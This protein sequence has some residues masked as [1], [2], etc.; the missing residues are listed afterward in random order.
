MSALASSPSLPY[1]IN[2]QG[3]CEGRTHPGKREPENSRGKLGL[4]ATALCLY[5]LVPIPRKPGE[6]R[7]NKK[8]P[9]TKEAF[10]VRASWDMAA[11][12]PPFCESHLTLLLNRG[13]EHTEFTMVHTFSIPEALSFQPK[14][15]THNLMGRQP[16]SL[17][18]RIRRC[19]GYPPIP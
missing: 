15:R 19:A 7:A 2:E 12:K 6:R 14:P 3:D 11:K 4:P 8:G 1:H 16:G 17:E 5:S 18:R 9:G 13:W 10:R